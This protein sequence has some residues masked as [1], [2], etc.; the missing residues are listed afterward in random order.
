MLPHLCTL[1]PF[2][3][4]IELICSSPSCSSVS[5]RGPVVPPRFSS[6]H[7]KLFSSASASTL[8]AGPPVGSP[9]V[10]LERGRVAKAERLVGGGGGEQLWQKWRT[11]GCRG[12]Y[13]SLD[14]LAAPRERLRR[15]RTAD[16]GAIHQ[17]ACLPG[18]PGCTRE[19]SVSRLSQSTAAAGAL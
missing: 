4:R 7:R 2:P 8:A 17:P 16:H 5:L 19:R 6:Q 11:P 3:R 15:P 13:F 18:S 12:S 1:L 14:A 10:E 9:T